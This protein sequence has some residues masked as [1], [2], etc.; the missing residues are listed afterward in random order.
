MS[1]KPHQ[2]T[3]ATRDTVSLH[4]MVGTPQDVISQVLGIDK[5]TL[6]KYYREEIDTAA[7]KANAKVGGSLFNKALSGDTAAQIFWLKTRAG[8]KER[9]EIDHQSS[10]GSMKPHF[11]V[12]FVN[13]N[14]K[15]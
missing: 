1:R 7:A 9:Q 6:L 2:P 10:D 13:A 15:D 8:F 5:K 4:V 3:K 11:T 14:A 12:E